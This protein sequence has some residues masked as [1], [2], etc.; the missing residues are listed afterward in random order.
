MNRTA[1]PGELDQLIAKLAYHHD[2]SNYPLIIQRGDYDGH[3]WLMC[4]G[5]GADD[6]GEVWVTTDHV[7]CS[8]IVGF[9]EDDA[10][11]YVFLRNNL[12]I[13]ISELRRLLEMLIPE[14]PTAGNSED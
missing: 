13:I 6:K 14:Q 3:N 11:A 2:N 9:A 10:E 4:W 12:P 5:N 1:M 8:E 7:R